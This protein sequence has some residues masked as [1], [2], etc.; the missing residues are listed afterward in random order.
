[1]FQ[2]FI[3]GAVYRHPHGSI[4]LSIYLK[5]YSSN[6]QLLI[7]KLS[8]WYNFPLLLI[9]KNALITDALTHNNPMLTSVYYSVLLSP[10]ISTSTIVTGEHICAEKRSGGKG[11]TFTPSTSSCRHQMVTMMAVMPFTIGVVTHYESVHRQP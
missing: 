5:S 3:V 7:T 1:M 6:P 9:H 2:S 8:R 4:R 10:S 11:I